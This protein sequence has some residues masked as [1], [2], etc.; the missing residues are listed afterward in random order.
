[1]A[2]KKLPLTQ[3]QSE[4]LEALKQFS[5][6]HNYSPTW[7]ELKEILNAKKEWKLKSVGAVGACLNGMRA[8]G[9]IKNLNKSRKARNL[10]II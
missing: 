6:K 3:K 8:K 4:V 2:I 10:Q 1:M 7:Q 5:E 9:W